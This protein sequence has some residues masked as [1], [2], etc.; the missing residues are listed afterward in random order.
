MSAT[1][2][3]TPGIDG[4]ATEIDVPDTLTGPESKLV[5]LFVAA[6]G[7]ATVDELHEALDIRKI[8][9]F[10]VL[11]TLSDRDMITRDGAA[12]VPTAS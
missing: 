11:E 4:I 12:Y 2:S 3:D 10:P 8:N 9:L 6:A 5:Y 1:R 7:E